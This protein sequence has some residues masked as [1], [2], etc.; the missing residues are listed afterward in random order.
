MN[1][2]DVLLRL[3]DKVEIDLLKGIVVDGEFEP[4][5]IRK[6]WS[7][8]KGHSKI[9]VDGADLVAHRVLWVL[10]FGPICPGI[11]LDHLCRQRSCI[12]PKH[13]DPVPSVI[14]TRR[15]E[16]VLFAKR[17]HEQHAA[18][19]GIREH[20]GEAAP[21]GRTGLAHTRP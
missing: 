1:K 17:H 8:G 5:W 10:L 18:P 19:A 12:N 7:T 13:L 11:L 4:C 6:G 20:H 3:F 2:A 16:A 21:R 15:G 9:S 14:N